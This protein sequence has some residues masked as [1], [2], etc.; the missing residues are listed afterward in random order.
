VQYV[1]LAS[2]IIFGDETAT[3]K[4]YQAIINNKEIISETPTRSHFLLKKVR[5]SKP[6]L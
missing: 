6:I 5:K 3:S 4:F 2:V 1:Y